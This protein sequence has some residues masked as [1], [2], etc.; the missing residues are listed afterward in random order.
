MNEKKYRSIISREKGR[1][2]LLRV[3]LPLFLLMAALLLFSA[4]SSDKTDGSGGS[5]SSVS[6]EVSDS[7][8]AGTSSGDTGYTAPSLSDFKTAASAYGEVTDLTDLLTYESAAVT[9]NDR[10]NII[11]M[12][13]SS[14]EEAERLIFE[15]SGSSG[16]SASNPHIARLRP[17]SNFAYYEENVPADTASGTE[18]YYGYYL[19]VDGTVLLVTGAPEDSE[20]VKETAG[21]LFEALGCP[22]E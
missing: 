7:G 2:F 4:C 15:E 11:F 3:L 19:R 20:L 12:K 14:P 21:E 6:A 5:S 10:L 8:T 17:G 1:H 16:D 18:A 22:A 13:A 9:D